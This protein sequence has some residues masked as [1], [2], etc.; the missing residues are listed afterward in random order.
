MFTKATES[1]EIM[2]AAYPSGDPSLKLEKF[3]VAW[4]EAI[5]AELLPA[6]MMVIEKPIQSRTSS[7][8]YTIMCADAQARIGETEAARRLF[9]HAVGRRDLDWPEAVY[10]AFTLFEN[11]HGTLETLREAKS[12]IHHEQLKL[13]RRRQK[14][15]EAE[16]QAAEQFQQ[17]ATAAAVESAP[18]SAAKPISEA[19][20]TDGTGDVQMVEMADAAASAASVPEPKEGEDEPQ[21]K[22]YILEFYVWKLTVKGPRE[23]HSSGHR[24]A[25]GNGCRSS[26]QILQH[27]E[28]ASQLF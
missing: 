16:A 18:A 24:F 23:Y 10:D 25:K 26:D 11:T 5:G 28:H 17:R 15:A 4:A 8:Q 6:V 27:R 21:L 22:R 20:P 3:F 2:A 12:K 13:N 19:R 1:I 14:A 7:Y 9:I